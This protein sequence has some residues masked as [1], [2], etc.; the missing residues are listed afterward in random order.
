MP[1]HPR[2][3]V[4][5][6][7]RTPKGSARSLGYRMPAEWEPMAR[8]WLTP[9]YND[10]TWP[11]CLPQAQEQ[12]S[13]F[14]RALQPHVEVATTQGRGIATN[15]SWIRDY[16]PIFVVRN[17]PGDKPADGPLP[18]KAAHD[19]QFNGW[20]GKYEVRD[21]D[22]VVPQHIARQ[23]RVPLW[24]HD[25]V[26]EGGSIEVNGLGSVM[27]TEQCLLNKNRNPRLTRAKIVAEIHEALGTRHVIWLPGGIVGDD[28]DGH[29][30]DIARFV[31]PNTVV[32]IKAPKG[33]QDYEVLNRNWKALAS[34]RD[35]DGKKLNIIEL[36]VPDPILYN[37]PADRFGPG[38]LN[39]VP[40][41]YANFLI[42]NG[43]VAVPIFGQKTDDKALRV[44][45]K[46]LPGRK[47]VGLRAEALVVGLGSF[48][49]LSQQEPV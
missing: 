27:T 10:E 37:F 19:F 46:A 9:P 8:V 3:A 30:D 34:A 5:A 32:G 26:L 2:T 40:A 36:P 43:V 49:C 21:L 20:G 18:A 35:Q 41:S 22:D 11:G 15:D 25:L 31:S 39:P 12:F 24:I 23:L 14:I 29:I 45:E 17:A 16:G 1:K 28:T 38:G 42:A 6:D 13:A 4:A 33:H 48:H 7:L 47:I 44:L